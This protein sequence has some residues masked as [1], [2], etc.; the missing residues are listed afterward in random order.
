MVRDY[1]AHCAA[2]NI[3]ISVYYQIRKFA[4]ETENDVVNGHPVR[5]SAMKKVMAMIGSQPGL[6]DA[7]KTAIAKSIG[8]SDRNI[9]KYK[10]W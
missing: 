7:Q 6:T 5:Y 4:N 10:T 8:W 3:P 1:E 2:Y 9:R